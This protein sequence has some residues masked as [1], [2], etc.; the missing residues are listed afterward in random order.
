MTTVMLEP[1]SL[2]RHRATGE[3][4]SCT[5]LAPHT[6]PRELDP[7]FSEDLLPEPE[8]W[9]P[10]AIMWR[11]RCPSIRELMR[12]AQRGDADPM[13]LALLGGDGLS[14]ADVARFWDEL[15]P[16]VG[17]QQYRGLDAAPELVAAVRARWDRRQQRALSRLLGRFTLLLLARW[18]PL[19]LG[20]G[21]APLVAADSYFE[22]CLL[23]HHVIGQGR[24]AYLRR[25]ADP[26]SASDELSAQTPWTKL[27]YLVTFRF[28]SLVMDAQKLRML[29]A[30]MPPYE[31]E[32]KTGIVPKPPPAATP[33]PEAAGQIAKLVS[34][35]FALMP[36]LR[37]SFQGP[38]FDHGY[39]EVR[40]TFR[41]LRDGEIVV[42]DSGVREPAG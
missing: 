5:H 34:G 12:R 14:A 7:A 21:N 18:E 30:L 40:P 42:V 31:R 39:P 33:Q 13:Q 32:T 20:R 6:P 27:R 9:H 11:E 29:E 10:E 23:A 41:L 2:Q 28:E 26:A 37:E 8:L 36:V 3:W 4:W 19:Y 16:L 24:D 38:R 25:F 22:L 15:V 1:V 35:F 17:S